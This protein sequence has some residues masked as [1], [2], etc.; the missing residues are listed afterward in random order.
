MRCSGLRL[1]EKS[2]G[3]RY[4][5]CHSAPQNLEKA[6]AC[7]FKL[8]NATTSMMSVNTACKHASTGEPSENQPAGGVLKLD[9]KQV[10]RVPAG[11]WRGAECFGFRDRQGQHQDSSMGCLSAYH[12]FNVT[13]SPPT[14]TWKTRNPKPEVLHVLPC[15]WQEG[16]SESRM[17]SGTAQGL[18]FCWELLRL[19]V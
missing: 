9:E 11:V 8:K 15:D 2:L 5:R 4:L 14:L 3:F 17:S 19:K 12:S 10:S 7:C 6:Q 13:R 18:N 16:S 1:Y